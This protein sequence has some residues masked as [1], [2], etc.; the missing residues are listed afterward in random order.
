[1]TT[2]E[3][4]IRGGPA[5]AAWLSLE[6]ARRWVKQG[7]SRFARLALSAFRAA[8]RPQ[9][10]VIRPLHRGLYRLHLT[11]A[12]V[13]RW[14]LQAVWFTPL[15]QSRLEA[16]APRLL[17]ENGMPQIL[18]PL[19]V[20]LGADCTVNGAATWTGRAASRVRPELVVG[21]N[22]TLGWRAVISVG[23]RV[24]IGDDALL[25]SDVHIAGYPG[26]PLDPDA[27]AAGLPDEDGQCGDVLIEQGAWIGAG[28][29]INAGVRIGRGTV[30][31]ARSVVTRDLPPGVLAAGAPARVIRALAE[32]AR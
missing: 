25:S 31:A 9:P 5:P 23:T 13:L 27:R 2:A 18:G 22:V 6:A 14:A 28:V 29:F 3:T 16:T 20:R 10:P 11:T 32:G 24:E 12:G 4:D 8:R 30:V 1:M 17:L 15:L 26:H 21:R 19:T 7:D